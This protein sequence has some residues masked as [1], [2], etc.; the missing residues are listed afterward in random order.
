MEDLIPLLIIVVS[1]II[2][3]F[4]SARKQKR[5]NQ[6]TGTFEEKDTNT[7]DQEIGQSFFRNEEEE[8]P[9]NGQEEEPRREETLAERKQ[10]LH[11]ESEAP[12]I[13]GQQPREQKPMV[14]EL[15]KP[16][17]AR[18]KK[19]PGEKSSIEAIKEKFD[20]EEAIIYSEIINRKY[21]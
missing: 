16:Q 18:I 8:Q 10:R 3:L 1:G 19:R 6:T 2:S 11:E 21:F 17:S 12:S 13:P 14:E 5:N 7:G 20:V 15:S 9:A 4:A